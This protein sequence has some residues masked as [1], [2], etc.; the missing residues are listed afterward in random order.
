M[1]EH[2]LEQMKESLA[3]G[4]YECL[5]HTAQQMEMM[6]DLM[7]ADMFIDCLGTDGVAVV[8]A[9]ARPRRVF[10]NYQRSAVGHIARRED[11]PAVYQ[12]FETAN[13]VR[14]LEAVT[15]ERNSV[16]QDVVPIFSTQGMLAGVLIAERDIT[17]ELRHEQKLRALENQ[18]EDASD[19]VLERGLLYREMNHRIKNQL[20]LLS[21]MMRIQG[22]RSP[23]AETRAALIENAAKI[24]A[25]ATVYDGIEPG[26]PTA[27][28]PMLQ[29]I[30]ALTQGIAENKCLSIRVQGDPCLIPGEQA[31]TA[32]MVVSELMINAVRHGFPGRENG[33]IRVGVQ[34]G[35]AFIT[36]TGWDNGRGFSTETVAPNSGM[37]LLNSVVREKLHGDIHWQS[38]GEGTGVTVTIPKE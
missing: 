19:E 20:Q 37:R 12:A 10:S 22:R 34:S 3:P 2:M 24:D 6:A 36:I 8:V 25:V 13:P 32:V 38:E 11:E 9:Q 15:Q 5:L 7:E 21:S 27:L 1:M 35:N 26:K 16:R 14:D 28:V 31:I 23:Q 33:Q 18:A 4:V 30:G 17:R 29:R